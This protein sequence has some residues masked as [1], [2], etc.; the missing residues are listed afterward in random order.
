MTR[1]SNNALRFA[2]QSRRLIVTTG[3]ALLASF[4][5][6]A[7]AHAQAGPDKLDVPV[8]EGRLY[9]L[10]SRPFTFQLHRADG[11]AWTEN[12]TIPAGKYFSVKPPKAGET[13]EIQ[14]ITGNG[15]GYVIIR[16]REPI[17]G[18]FL[19]VRLPAINPA[20]EQIQPTWFAVQDS[21]GITRLVQE[22]SVA[23]AQSVQEALKKQP[24]MTQQE[25]ERSKHMLRANWVLTD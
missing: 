13:T 6:T 14:G 17:L 22:P 16:H 21:N 5:C 4:A 1:T 7:L 24:A 3:L 15:R 11:A 12:Y 18:G 20:N 25:I 9:N 10:T 8:G 19:T 23:Q 2:A